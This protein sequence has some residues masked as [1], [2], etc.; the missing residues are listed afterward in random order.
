MVAQ[1]AAFVLGAKSP[2]FCRIGTTPS[3]KSCS[4]C[5]SASGI[6]VE[7]IGRTGPEPALD[8]VRDL[9]RRADDH[10]VPTAARQFANQLP[11][12][13]AV[14]AARRDHVR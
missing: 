5:G 14:R 2:R 10:A 3:T 1:R 7:P 8:V 12:R 13:V 6:E 11:H 9:L 4:P